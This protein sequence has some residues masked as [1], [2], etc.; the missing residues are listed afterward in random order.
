MRDAGE[1]GFDGGGVADRQEKVNVLGQGLGGMADNQFAK[2][3]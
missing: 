3:R 1:G 2:Q